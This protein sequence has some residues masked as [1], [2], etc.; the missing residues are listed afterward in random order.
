MVSGC[1]RPAALSEPERLYSVNDELQP[2]RL[3]YQDNDLWARYLASGDRTGFRNEIITARM[4]AIDVNYTEYEIRLTRE[5]AEF[6]VATAIANNGLTTASTLIVDPATKSVL[7]GAASFVG[8][9]GTAVNE[10]A[11]LKQSIQHVQAGM[12]QS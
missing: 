3:A 1:W 5:G 10:K 9:T 8:F 6:D 12:R 2:V 11:L 7:S 4:Y